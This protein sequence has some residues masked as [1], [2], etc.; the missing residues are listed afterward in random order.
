MKT[1]CVCGSQLGIMK[2]KCVDG[3]ICKSCYKKTSNNFTETIKHKTLSEIKQICEDNQTSHDE[4]FEITGKIGNYVLFDEKH[5]KICITNN[6]LT[7][8]QAKKPEIC[9]IQEIENCRIVTYP[10]YSI[11]QLETMVNK[12]DETL[13][14][15]L[16]IVIDCRDHSKMEIL[17]TNSPMRIK[18]YAFRKVLNFAIRIE[19]KINDMK[20]TR[21]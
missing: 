11:N 21:L 14:D 19:N 6:R 17:F 20:G 18:S 3:Y 16:K 13:I 15:S 12:R 1:C 4:V 2:F 10:K 7:Q 5:Q 8:Q 9:S